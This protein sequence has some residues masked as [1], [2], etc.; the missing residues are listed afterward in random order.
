MKKFL[1]IMMILISGKSIAVAQGNTSYDIDFTS[2]ESVVNAIF[3]AAQTGD[4][5]ILQHLCPPI[6]DASDGDVK[7]LCSLSE[8]HDDQEMVDEFVAA[9]KDGYING[10]VTY[11]VYQGYQLAEVPF[12]F[13]PRD[14]EMSLVKLYGNWYLADY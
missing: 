12:E 9:F 7:D 14:E 4:F 8:M 2:P 13:G 6:A 1:L 11:R 10:P 3:Y 5:N